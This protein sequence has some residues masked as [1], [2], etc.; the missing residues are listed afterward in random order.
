[1]DPARTLTAFYRV[2]ATHLIPD[3]AKKIVVL[4]CTT[5]RVPQYVP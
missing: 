1:M 5:D 2:D 3:D 4:G